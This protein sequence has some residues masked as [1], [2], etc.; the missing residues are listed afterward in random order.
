MDEQDRDIKWQVY[1][2]RWILKG[3]VQ[4]DLIDGYKIDLFERHNVGQYMEGEI[5]TTAGLY[6][7]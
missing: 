6:D 4:L 2:G 1:T 7:G 3:D 5:Q